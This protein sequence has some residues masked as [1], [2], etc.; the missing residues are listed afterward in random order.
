MS[1][2]SPTKADQVVG[3]DVAEAEFNR[4]ISALK[5]KLNLNKLKSKQRADFEDNKAIVLDALKDGSL[6][7]DDKGQPYYTP[8]CDFPSGPIR[9]KK[10]KG[11]TLMAG[12]GLGEDAGIERSFKMMAQLT[13]QTPIHLEELDLD[14]LEVPLAVMT[15]L[16]V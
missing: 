12:N 15:I 4:F 10:P 5:A 16:L 1:D 6:R 8:A 3:D 13:G 9:F 14:E 11:K 2:D 7:V